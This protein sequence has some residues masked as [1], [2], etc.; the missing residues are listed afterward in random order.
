MAKARNG[1][2][3]GLDALLGGLP[4]EVETANP[5]MN[6]TQAEAGDDLIDHPVRGPQHQ[7]RLRIRLPDRRPNALHMIIF[8]EQSRP[9]CC[10]L[11]RLTFRGD[12]GED[13]VSTDE[14]PVIDDALDILF[15]A[16]IHRLI[17]FA[18]AAFADQCVYFHHIALISI[19]SSVSVVLLRRRLL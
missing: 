17:A 3:R 6:Q 16:Q 5:L 11:R 9:D 7:K 19:C 2:G 13:R 8:M 1:L 4:D 18:C 12:P 15:L 14:Q 10:D